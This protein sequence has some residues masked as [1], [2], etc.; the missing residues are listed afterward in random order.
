[1]TPDQLSVVA[2]D[3]EFLRTEW[4]AEVHNADIRRGSAILRRLLID[5]AYGTAWRSVGHGGEPRVIAVDLEQ[6]MSR[7]PRDQ[8]AMALA[9]GVRHRG[10]EYAGICVAKGLHDPSPEL[11]PALSAGGFPGE[12]EYRLSAYLASP[13]AVVGRQTISRREVIKYVANVK[14][15]VHLGARARRAE[16]KLVAR[17]AAL[18][19]RF[20]V[21]GTDGLLL[22]ILA[23]GQAIG[24]SADAG[25]LVSSVLGRP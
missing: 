16:L 19:R 23:I 11:S 7:I 17:V 9:T 4:H 10:V 22:E 5:D 6:F 15:G 14:G 1:L 2:E 8:I 3:L 12:F 18:E 24:R 25:R 20:D 21:E 13:S